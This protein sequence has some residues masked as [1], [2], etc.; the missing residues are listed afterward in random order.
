[1]LHIAQFEL[2]ANPP[3]LINPGR[4]TGSLAFILLGTGNE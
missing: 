1:M 2:M 3:G 4:S